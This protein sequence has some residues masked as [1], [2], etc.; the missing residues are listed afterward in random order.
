MSEHKFKYN[1]L[2]KVW[3]RVLTKSND[4][5]IPY[6]N[7]LMLTPAPDLA[8]YPKTMKDIKKLNF[9][10]YFHFTQPEE[11]LYRP[12]LPTHVID[13][14]KASVDEAMFDTLVNLNFD[15]RLIHI[16]MPSGFIVEGKACVRFCRDLLEGPD[17][18]Y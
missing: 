7:E 2:T 10:K 14:L 1:L 8:G 5:D 6:Q 15:H 13:S 4:G 17:R 16:N 12:T 18:D 11:V 9:V 3:S